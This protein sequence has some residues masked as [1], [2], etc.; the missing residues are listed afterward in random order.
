MK[1][2]SSTWRSGFLVSSP[3]RKS[4]VLFVK[5][6]FLY[7]YHMKQPEEFKETEKVRKQKERK[8]QTKQVENERRVCLFSY[9]YREF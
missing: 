9:F 1:T 4:K 2:S 6:N 8:S 3:L 7:F 5:F